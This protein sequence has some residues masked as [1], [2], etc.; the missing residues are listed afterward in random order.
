MDRE[1]LNYSLKNDGRIFV[2]FEKGGFIDDQPTVTNYILFKLLNAIDVLIEE[3][4]ILQTKSYTQWPSGV[5]F[6]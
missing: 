3:V 6:I 5:A 2:D 1:N 4:R